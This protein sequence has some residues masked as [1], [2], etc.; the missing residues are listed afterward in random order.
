MRPALRY[1]GSKYRLAPWIISH[2]PEH[3]I[4]VEPFGGSASVLLLQPRSYGE[5]YNDLDDEIVTVFRVLQDDRQAERLCELIRLTP[6]ARA[7]FE[8]SYQRSDDPVEQARRT[9]FR[10][11]A[12]HGTTG[13]LGERTGFRAKNTTTRRTD[14]DSWSTYPEHIQAFVERLKG[15]V[16]EN[17]DALEVLA[18]HD[19]PETLHYVDPPYVWNTRSGKRAG[20]AYRHEMTNEE[21]VDLAELLD[22]LQGHVVL[23]GYPS[24]LYTEMYGSWTYHEKESRAAGGEP[25]MEGLWVRPSGAAR[26]GRAQKQLSLTLESADAL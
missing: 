15:V 10:S 25:R 16:I 9:I 18:I 2:F 8:L 3:R 13:A 24:E 17:R 22:S 12:A 5:V 7:E 19:G 11:F 4:Y 14:P 23:S 21:H 20:R 26:I 1:H 6:F